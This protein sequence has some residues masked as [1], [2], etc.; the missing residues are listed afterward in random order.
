M[1]GEFRKQKLKK[2][3]KIITIMAIT[4]MIISMAI[5]GRLEYLT[6]LS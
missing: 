1:Q 2:E 6:N 5:V 4:V 3:Q